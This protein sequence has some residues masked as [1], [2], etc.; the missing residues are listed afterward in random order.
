MWLYSASL[1]RGSQ[2]QAHCEP[3]SALQPPL[4]PLAI[5]KLALQA[6]MR[7]HLALFTAASSLPNFPHNLHCKLLQGRGHDLFGDSRHC[8]EG[9]ERMTKARSKNFF[10][11]T[12]TQSQCQDTRRPWSCELDFERRV[13]Q[14]VLVQLR[15]PKFH[16][17]YWVVILLISM[18]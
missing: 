6:T 8:W 9:Q 12:G 7:C 15:C 3:H 1:L 13:P 14:K 10:C 16:F 11:L 5:I 2:S 17:S 4:N 18:L